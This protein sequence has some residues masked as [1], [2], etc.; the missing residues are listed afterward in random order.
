MV[1][2]AVGGSATIRVRV[3]WRLERLR[4]L[5]R[6]GL[7]HNQRG[8]VRLAAA[9]E[10]G[11]GTMTDERGGG[12]SGGGGDGGGRRRRYRRGESGTRGCGRRSLT[13][14]QVSWR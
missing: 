5:A 13:A 3:A 11:T 12:S 4:G 10:L 8:S 6:L 14:C 7:W 1:G 2:E 9:G